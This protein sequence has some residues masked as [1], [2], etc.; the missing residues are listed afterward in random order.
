MLITGGSQGSRT[1]NRAAEESWPLW[2]EGRSAAD[3]SDRI[4]HAYEELAPNFGESGVDGRSRRF[5]DDM[6]RA[7]AEAD[8]VVS[9]A[10]M[11]AVSEL[12][13]AGKPSILVPLPDARAISISCAM[14]R[15]SR[16][17]ERRGWCWI[18]E[19][20]GERLVE[21]VTRLAR[22]SGLLEEMG[23]AA[24][25]LR[26]SRGRRGGRRMCWKSCRRDRRRYEAI[27]TTLE[28]AE[29]IHY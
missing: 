6:P 7:F 18:A 17:P 5:I 28:K 25:S 11:G 14:R 12:A 2:D 16:K 21:E 22:D 15:R 27:D 26:A 13:A 20:T 29:T 3:S 24:R 8:L 1:L 19:M 9:R 4:A 10:G 23:A